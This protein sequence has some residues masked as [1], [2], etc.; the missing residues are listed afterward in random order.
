MM[1][2]E[3]WGSTKENNQVTSTGFYCELFL[4]TS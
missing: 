4:R 2:Q 3:F 1:L